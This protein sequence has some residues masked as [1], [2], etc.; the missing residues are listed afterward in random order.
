[1]KN[2]IIIIFLFVFSFS[3]IS[4]TNNNIENKMSMSMMSDSECKMN[5]MDCVKINT[6]CEDCINC[7]INCINIAS[8]LFILNIDSRLK[9]IE[10]KELLNP[11]INNKF[12]TKRIDDLFRPPIS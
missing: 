12:S 3:S 9:T 2:V 1:M 11:A 6:I 7:E 10:I 8:N 5:T 4:Q